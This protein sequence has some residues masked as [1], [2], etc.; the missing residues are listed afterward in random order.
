MTSDTKTALTSAPTV[1]PDAEYFQSIEEHFVSR[2]GDPLFLSNADWLLIRAW[3]QAGLPLRVVIRGINDALDAHAHSWS[4]ARKV[5]SLRYCAAEVE[6]AAER[7]RRALAGGHDETQLGATLESL[8]DAL[9]QAPSLG[10]G[11]AAVAAELAHE[12]RRQ[13]DTAEAGE[14]LEAWL[15]AGEARLLAAIDADASDEERRAIEAE[16][17]RDL[18]V[19][20]DRLPERVLAQVR[21]ESLARRRLESHGLTRMSLWSL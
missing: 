20:R 8:A 1:D 3:R 21:E 6:T 18:A 5:G 7:W 19:Y 16:V 11:A 13:S 2:R 10:P 9:T 15:R 17:D 12:L 14:S 4:R